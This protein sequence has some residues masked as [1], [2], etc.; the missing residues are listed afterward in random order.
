MVTRGPCSLRVVRAV[1]KCY[2]VFSGA[3]NLPFLAPSIHLLW[4]Y[5]FTM[6]TSTPPTTRRP[7]RPV[8]TRGFPRVHIRLP[9][10]LYDQVVASAAKDYLSLNSEII[11]RLRM[12][13]A[14]ATKINRRS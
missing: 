11:R 5:Q 4:H 6:S 10:D 2:K 8:L 7:G 14:S 3:I 9:P 13:Y 1:I 12:S